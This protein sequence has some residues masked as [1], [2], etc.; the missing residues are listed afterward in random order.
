MSYVL[1]M[2]DCNLHREMLANELQSHGI[3]CAC[4][5]TVEEGLQYVTD[6]PP[7]LII[8]E[9]L[10]LGR[11]AYGFYQQLQNHPHTRRIP[12]LMIT[13]ASRGEIK[14]FTK[15]SRGSV[16]CMSKPYQLSAVLSAVSQL[17]A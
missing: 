3:P 2:D 9:P 8:L 5:S 17:A 10:A 15:S 12:T 13:A 16:T 7:E 6:L 14:R 11:R 4:V 1:L